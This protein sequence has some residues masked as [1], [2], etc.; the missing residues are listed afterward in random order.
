MLFFGYIFIYWSVLLLYIGRKFN[1]KYEDLNV[2]WVLGWESV[3]KVYK[4]LYKRGIIVKV[5][6]LIYFWFVKFVVMVVVK[7][8]VID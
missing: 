5:N 2:L 8:F 6:I 7:R 1:N 4:V 3:C